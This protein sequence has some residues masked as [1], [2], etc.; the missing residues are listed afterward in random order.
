MQAVDSRRLIMGASFIAAALWYTSAPVAASPK[1][2]TSE[3]MAPI[4][5]IMAAATTNNLATMKKSYTSSPVIID[6][7]APYRWSG[8][9]AVATWF[10]DF[11]AWLT[12]VKG[13]QMHGTFAGPGYW[14]ATKDRAEIIMPTTFTFLI[15]GKAAAESGLWTFVLVKNGGSWRAESSAWAH[16]RLTMKH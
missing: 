11:G 16:M 1:M 2:P 15:A 14:D 8:P 5:A 6:E 10:A 4:N 3:M 13:T 12:M 9:N 7:F